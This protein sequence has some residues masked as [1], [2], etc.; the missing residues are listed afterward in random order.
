MY[1]PGLVLTQALG[2]YQESERGTQSSLTIIDQSNNDSDQMGKL[3]RNSSV[4]TATSS[5]IASTEIQPSRSL[6]HLI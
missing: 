3:V 6:L 1:P 5:S 2:V 4:N